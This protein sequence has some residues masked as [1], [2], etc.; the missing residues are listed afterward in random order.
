MEE[1]VRWKQRFSN[2]K[3]AFLLLRDALDGDISKLNQLEKEGVIQRFEYTF[4]LAWKVLKDRMEY[5][6]IIFD[7]ISPKAVIRKAYES[8]YIDNLEVWFNMIGDR[9]LMSH[10]YDEN[11]F[12]KIIMTTQSE[13]L[14]ILDKLYM[15]LL[16]E[17]L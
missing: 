3:R 5:D 6:G 13:Y 12:E 8:K 4:E 14:T 7:I 17:T 11:K 9:N 10:T 16:E 1:D 15:W 2:F